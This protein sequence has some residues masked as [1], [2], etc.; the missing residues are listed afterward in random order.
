M[1]ELLSERF[2]WNDFTG[3]Q[4]LLMVSKFTPFFNVHEKLSSDFFNYLIEQC[5]NYDHKERPTAQ[6]LYS[7]L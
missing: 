2:A 6:E 7:E 4:I 3:H 1:Y 5:T